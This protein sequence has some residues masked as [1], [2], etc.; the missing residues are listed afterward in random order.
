MSNICYQQTDHVATITIDRPEK[1]NTMTVAMD[2]DFNAACREATLDDAVRAVV[3]TGARGEHGKAFC[4]GS[5]ITDLD[6]YGTNWQYRNRTD[7]GKD[8]VYGLWHVRKPVVAALFGYCIGGGLELACASDIRVAEPSTRFAAGEI[9]WGWH[10]GSGATQFLTR[11]VGPG[12]AC[13]LLLTGE[14]IDAAEAHRIG[15]TQ[16]P[17]EPGAAV[18]TARTLAERIA[19]MAPIAA[20]SAKNLVR[21]AT[22]TS[23]EVGM[24]YENDMFAYCMLT[25]D[26]AEGRHAFAEKRTPSFRGE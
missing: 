10:G 5:D 24:R 16:I 12:H 4:A 26:A 15:L 18:D 20:Q 17:A 1:L 3:L 11:A 8:Y 13:R 25:S 6:E 9:R 19:A 23:V 21:V 2:A 7:A 22:S 14:Q